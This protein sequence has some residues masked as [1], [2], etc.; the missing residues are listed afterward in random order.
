[1]HGIEGLWGIVKGKILKN[2]RY[3]PTSRTG[4]AG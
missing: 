2:E 3:T 4:N 1:M